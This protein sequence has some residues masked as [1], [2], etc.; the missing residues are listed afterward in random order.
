[1]EILNLLT[2]F[3]F[4]SIIGSFLNVV[5]F[6]LNSGISFVSGSSRCFS[7]N[8]K[9]DRYELIPILSFLVQKGRCS[10]CKSKISK[11]YILVETA[12]GLLFVLA[13]IA[14]S[15]NLFNLSESQ[16]GTFLLY[17]VVTSLSIVLFVYDLKHKI[18]PSSVLYSLVIVGIVYSFL[19][20]VSGSRAFIDVIAG[21]IIALPTFFLWLVSKGRWIGFADSVL[22]LVVGSLLGLALGIQ[23]F[24]FSFWVGA[25][26]AIVL[27][28]LLP[29]KF[30]MKS[31][32]P[33]GP[34]IIAAM[35]FFLF[36]QNDIL[37][38]LSLYDIFRQ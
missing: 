8:K 7:C 34:F 12:S 25:I 28:K 35:L 11:Q 26:V 27:T 31:E 14:T 13:A 9:L 20:Y 29:K 10:S 2:I 23:T 4:G 18:L 21:F 1:M 16:L 3:I 32:I 38:L 24:L 17:I 5:I 19:L 37:N 36:T 33:F 15:F 6:R 30:G 22:F